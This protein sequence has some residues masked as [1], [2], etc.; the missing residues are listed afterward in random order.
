[1]KDVNE[2]FSELEKMG[3]IDVGHT[4]GTLRDH[5]LGTYNIL[6]RW[7]CSEEL[8]LAGLCHSI[9]G[10]ES[11]QKQTIS[12]NKRNEIRE[13]IGEEAEA[14]VYYFGAHVKEHFWN[15]LDRSDNFEILDRFI[16]ETTFVSFAQISDLV[17]LTLA[18]WLEQRP[19]VDEKYLYLRK[20]E[21]T[22]SERFLP[23][24]AYRDFK[25]AYQLNEERE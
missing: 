3:V 5:L 24:E 2:V 25:L 19:R 23:A 21:F 20:E 22:A 7:N 16:G 13:L 1:M 10:T 14:L 12:L 4:N 17:T 18:N 15:L 9:Y 8:C 6:R 11:F